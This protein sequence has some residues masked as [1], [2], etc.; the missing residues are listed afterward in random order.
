LSETQTHDD[1]VQS[2]FGVNP[3]AHGKGKKTD[4]VDG[5]RTKYKKDLDEIEA[6]SGRVV[7]PSPAARRARQAADGASRNGT[8]A[9]Q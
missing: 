4:P 3:K 7:M 9:H 6:M 5:F 8:G 2:V 1:W